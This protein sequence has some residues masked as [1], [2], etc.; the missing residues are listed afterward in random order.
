MWFGTEDDKRQLAAFQILL[1]FETLSRRA[2]DSN[3]GGCSCAQKIAVDQLLC[4]ADVASR[5][6]AGAGRGRSCQIECANRWLRANCFT[7]AT[8]RNS[9]WQAFATS[10]GDIPFV[11]IV[12]H[13]QNR[14]RWRFFKNQRTVQI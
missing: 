9:I 10:S 14:H 11:G 13:V 5:D 2:Q 4:R 3:P 1:I 7:P 6:N 12:E 8:R